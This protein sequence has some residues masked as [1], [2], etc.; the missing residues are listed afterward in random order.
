MNESTSKD[1]TMT[2]D[3]F[4][5]ECAIRLIDPTTALENEAIIDALQRRHDDEVIRILNEEF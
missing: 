5:L 3:Q 2:A 4:D 1:K